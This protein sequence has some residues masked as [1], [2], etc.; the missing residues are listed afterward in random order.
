MLADGPREVLFKCL[1]YP[2]LCQTR[3][4][5]SHSAF[6]TLMRVKFY[7]VPFGCL[8]SCLFFTERIPLHR[9]S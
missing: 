6:S 9:T 3:P 2:V 1:I 8:Q 5:N 7:T 4:Q